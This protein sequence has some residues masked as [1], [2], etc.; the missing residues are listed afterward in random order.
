[1]HSANK[2]LTYQLV[3]ILFNLSTF[4]THAKPQR[5][6]TFLLTTRFPPYKEIK[7][8]FNILLNFEKYYFHGSMDRC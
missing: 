7:T 5:N 6:D 4:V 3:G 8:R 2:E 1:M